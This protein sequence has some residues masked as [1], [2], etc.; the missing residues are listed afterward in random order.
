MKGKDRSVDTPLLEPSCPAADGGAE[1]APS[2]RPKGAGTVAIDFHSPEFNRIDDLREY[3]GDLLSFEPLDHIVTAHERH[4]T[5]KRRERSA[6][7]SFENRRMAAEGPADESGEQEPP[8]PLTV[9]SEGRVLIIDSERE[10]AVAC[11]KTLEQGGLSCTLVIVKGPSQ[12]G[13]VERRG[14]RKVLEVD[15]LSVTGAFGAFSAVATIGGEKRAPAELHDG[16]ACF[17]LVLDLQPI[18]AFSGDAL[19]LGYYAPGAGPGALDEAMAELP[20]MRG[21]F[22]RPQFVSFREDRCLH[23]VSRTRDCRK[24]LE[25]CSVGAVRSADRKISIDHYLCQG[26]GGCAL[27]CPADAI[28]VI[29]P[30]QGHLLSQMYRRLRSA[31]TSASSPV[32][33]VISDLSLSREEKAPDA[34]EGRSGTV[35]RLNVP[36]I[37]NVRLHLL[38]AAFVYGARDA[39]VVCRSENPS[40]IRRGVESQVRLACVILQKLGLGE[41]RVRFSTVPS[42]GASLAKATAPSTGPEG[43]AID[44]PVGEMTSAYANDPRASVLL[45]AQLLRE[46]CGCRE[47]WISLPSGSPFGA[48]SVDA[49]A[50]T[51]CMACVSACPAGALSAGGDA[52][53]LLFRESRCH[54]CGLC[55]EIC[56]EGAITLVPGILLERG[57]AEAPAVLGEGEPLRCVVCGVPFA[58]HALIDHI[59][60][61]LAGHW[62]YASERQLRRLQMCGTCRARDAFASEEM[63]SWN[64]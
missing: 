61:K 51:L 48:V 42:E 31:S 28:R 19:P 58:S 10:R 3:S 39:L 25:I 53:R 37:A 15:T 47:S 11:G 14:R 49:S 43:R 4:V 22:Q 60:E 18:P 56:P 57:A 30:P 62:M 44:L 59:K 50:C 54:Q 6:L 63:R 32:R 7:D 27:L 17:D 55:R 52:P 36:H 16:A 8:E 23:G 1:N 46:Q 21:R 5:E 20:E 2:A 12:T 9:I 41:E 13:T 45:A 29:H 40:N 64:L 33:I 35:V 38:L 26:C 34:D 24:C